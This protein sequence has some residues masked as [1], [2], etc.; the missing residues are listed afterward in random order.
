MN[1]LACSMLMAVT[2]LTFGQGP[3]GRSLFATSMES[4]SNLLT[5]A[6]EAF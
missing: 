5:S 1:A 2:V 6:T 4:V 3:A